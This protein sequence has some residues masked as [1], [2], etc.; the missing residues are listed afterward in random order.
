MSV[1]RNAKPDTRLE[2][3]GC[4]EHSVDSNG[5]KSITAQ[6]AA[7]YVNEIALELRT[8]ARSTELFFLAYLLELVIEES[9]VQKRGQL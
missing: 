1:S 6:D 8:L 5:P 7:S 2:K 4:K 3:E 9:A